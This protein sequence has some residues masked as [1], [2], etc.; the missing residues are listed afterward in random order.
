MGGM[1][2]SYRDQAIVLRSYKLGEADRIVVLLGK[3]SGLIR[4]VAKGIRRTSSRFGGRLDAF[5]AVDI[6]LHRGRNLDT[7]MQVEMLGGYAAPLGANYE[8]FTAA[9]VMAETTQK[10]TEMHPEVGRDYF[11][12]LHGALG[13]LAARR[14]P[15]GMLTAS[16]LLRVM[17]VAGWPPTLDGCAS[18]GEPATD[19][20]G[21]DQGG[22]VCED[23][24][25]LGSFHLSVQGRDQLEA[26]LAGNWDQCHDLPAGTVD[27]AV[28]VAIGW[29]QFHLEQR[30]RSSL[31][32]NVS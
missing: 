24:G 18:C 15:T 23:C 26:L 5:N 20:F 2:R 8:A 14:H 13:A 17:S 21:W 10:L 25:S 31:F 32:L 6:Q 16:F 3:E 19:R 30:L 7:I 28:R 1:L 22:T 29:T 4:A 9:K 11:P 12:L 27:E